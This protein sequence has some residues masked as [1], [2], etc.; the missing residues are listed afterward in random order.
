MFR[1]LEDDALDVP[2][3]AVYLS[4][5]GERHYRRVATVGCDAGLLPELAGPGDLPTRVTGL[6]VVG[7]PFGDQVTE[8]VVLP[9][10][11][12]RDADPVGLLLAG[13]SPSR[14]LDAEYRSFHEWWPAS[15]PVSWRTSA[16]SR[17]SGCARSRWPS[18]TAPR[19][20]SSPT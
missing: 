16:P 2:F 13:K 19:P 12:S 17:P 14:A 11:P 1:A 3:A 9:L 4:V 20:P 18:S 8:A 15:S 6:G 7:G 10:A 5:P